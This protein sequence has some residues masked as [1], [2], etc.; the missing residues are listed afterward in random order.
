PRRGLRNTLEDQP[1]HGGHLAPIAL[2][3][4]HDELEAGGVAH[5]LVWPQTDRLL[6]EALEA[7]LLDVLLGHDP[8]GPGR[9]R[10]VEGHEIGEWIEQVEPYTIRSD[11][12]DF[13]DLLLEDFGAF[14]PLKAE[15]HVL[16]CEG[17]AVVK[18]QALAQLELVDAL[19]CAHRPRLGEARRH[20]LT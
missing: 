6:L 16:G 18:L 5:E 10:P 2:E 11:D 7:H 20:G 17:I 9:E 12:L 1:L 3:R 14:R 13:A 19:V 8:R 4:L 15:L